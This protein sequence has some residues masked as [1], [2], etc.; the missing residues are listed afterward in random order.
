VQV[1]RPGGSLDGGSGARKASTVSRRRA[2]PPPAGCRCLP[3]AL[4]RRADRRRAPVLAAGHSPLPAS[5]RPANGR[6]PQTGRAR[7]WRVSCL[8]Q[9]RHRRSD[10][11]RSLSR[12]GDQVA[13]RS[14]RSP[15]PPM[16]ITNRS[17]CRPA[18][19]ST[20]A[21]R[22]VVPPRSSTDSGSRPGPTRDDRD[23]VRRTPAHRGGRP[24][25]DSAA[26]ASEHAST[27]SARSRACQAPSLGGL[28]VDVSGGESDL[29]GEAHAPPRA[30]R[31]P[32]PRGKLA[33]RLLDHVD[34][35]PH[36]LD[37]LLQGDA[38]RELPRRRTEDRPCRLHAFDRVAQPVDERGDACLGYQ[39]DDRTLLGRQVAEPANR[40][41]SGV[42]RWWPATP[43]QPRRA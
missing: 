35:Q 41:S 20:P 37:G 40:R 26:S 28:G 21:C 39:P 4:S 18:S 2:R 30:R 5:A 38:P 3:A 13:A 19:A 24:C 27:S 29:S 6:H 32:R 17:P 25:S 31:L 23:R 33:D 36:H 42:P 1:H 12:D 11:D 10:D 43:L 15:P 34:R 8:A 14:I 22:R 9:C 16:T 7:R